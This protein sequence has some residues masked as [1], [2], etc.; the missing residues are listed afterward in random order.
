MTG[1]L[2][3]TALWG[4]DGQFPGSRPAFTVIVGLDWELPLGASSAA[5]ERDAAE[6]A[7]EAEQARRDDELARLTEQVAREHQTLVTAGT[8]ATIAVESARLATALA[9]AESR[10]LTLGTA[11]T[12]DL[13]SA[14]QAAREA[15]LARLRA[16]A[17][18]AIAALALAHLTGDLVSVM[19]LR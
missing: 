10:K 1:S 12:T 6:A 11:I 7:L 3:A 18:R 8:S 4:E 5:A 17:D 2:G 16:E 13:V 14:Q 9:D 19:S 15:E